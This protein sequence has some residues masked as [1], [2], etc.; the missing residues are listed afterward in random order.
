MPDAIDPAILAAANINPAT[1]LATDYLNHFN[2]VAMLVGMLSMMP[3][4]TDEVLAWRPCGYEEHF[5]RTG[6]REKALAVA[7]FRSAHPA[8]LGRF[9]AACARAETQ[10]AS[11]QA[12][13]VAGADPALLDPVPIQEAIAGIDAVINEGASPDPEHAAIDALFD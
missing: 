9:H 8:L 12:S 4:M 5:E 2:E 13:L 6:F 11:V 3:E 1:G 7:A 10:I